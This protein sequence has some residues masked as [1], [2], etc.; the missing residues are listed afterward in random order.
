MDIA[1]QYKGGGAKAEETLA[2]RQA[3]VRERLTH[4]L[5]HGVTAFIV[6][7]T[8]EMRQEIANRGERPI[9]VIE[10]PLINLLS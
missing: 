7:D 6:E 5:V 9:E 4:A 2:W 3:G 8:E 1:D 10:G